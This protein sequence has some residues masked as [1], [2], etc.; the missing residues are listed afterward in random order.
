MRE[1][2]RQVSRLTLVGG[3]AVSTALA[4]SAPPAQD[5][6]Q[7][8]VARGTNPAEPAATGPAAEHRKPE[9]FEG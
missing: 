2:L 9:K 6:R 3:F 8:N 1:I 5:P 4:Q 7:G